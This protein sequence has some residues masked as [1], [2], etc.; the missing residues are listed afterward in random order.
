MECVAYNA[1]L[2][3]FFS[4]YI[5]I[6]KSGSIGIVCDTLLC[7]SC[8]SLTYDITVDTRLCVGY[9][10]KVH[11]YILLCILLILIKLYGIAQLYILISYLTRCKCII[12][13]N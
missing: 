12:L 2:S 8:R 9:V 10:T 4:F 13:C 1:K 5:H 6:Q 7:R 11:G 3:V